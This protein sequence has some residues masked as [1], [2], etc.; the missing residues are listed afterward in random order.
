[1][2]KVRPLIGFHQQLTYCVTQFVEKDSTLAVPL[3]HCILRYWPAPC[4]SKEVLFL[5]EIE[6]ILELTPVE[7]FHKIVYVLFRQ[8]A[9]CITSPHFQVAER[10][11]YIWQNN[12]VG[13]LISEHRAV[14]LPLVYA[15]LRRNEDHW[16]ETC[17]S[18]ARSVLNIFADLDSALLARC[19][20][21]LEEQK[22]VG[23]LNA[24]RRGNAWRQIEAATKDQVAKYPGPAPLDASATLP[25]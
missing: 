18:L 9:K 11:L 17:A 5:S 6:E 2:H 12:Y 8:I 22:R 4:S 10:A 7:E 15:A 21:E 19:A 16:N 1:M 3:I 13:T 20:A 24:E 14:I 23:A 25:P